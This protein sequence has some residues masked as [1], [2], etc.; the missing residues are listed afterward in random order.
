MVGFFFHVVELVV[1][2]TDCG[3][4]RMDF[5]EPILIAVKIARGPP[6]TTMQN[7][8]LITK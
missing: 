5:D 3:E 6:P 4:R 7:A 1:R 8:N 2:D